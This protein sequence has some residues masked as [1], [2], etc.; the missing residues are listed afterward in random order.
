MQGE[1]LDFD[2]STVYNMVYKSLFSL[3]NLII[4]QMNVEPLR[5]SQ[6]DDDDTPKYVSVYVIQFKNISIQ[7]QT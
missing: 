2:V 3:L 7:T 4:T 5:F 1:E 6:Q